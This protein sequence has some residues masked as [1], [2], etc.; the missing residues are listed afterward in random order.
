MLAP[1][2]VFWFVCN[3]TRSEIAVKQFS[4]IADG[5]FHEAVRSCDIGHKPH[6]LR[7][8]IDTKATVHVGEYSR[9]GRSRGITAVKALDPNGSLPGHEA[10]RANRPVAFKRH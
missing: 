10:A 2:R 7:I 3:G 9:G 1:G 5:T 6:T 8:S 4:L